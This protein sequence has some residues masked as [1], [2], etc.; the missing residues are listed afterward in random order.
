MKKYIETAKIMFKTQM[1]YRF[2]I[3]TSMIFTISKILLAYVLWGAIFGKQTVISG[4]TFNSML[5]YYIISTFLSQLDQSSNVG[6]QI[7]G[8]IRNGS[9]SKYIIRPIG[10]FRYFTAQTA[11]VTTFLLSFNLIAAV[12][13]IFIFRINFIISSNYYTIFAALS[14]TFL[15]LLFMIQINYFIGILAFKFLDT[16]IFMMIKDNLVQ[17]VTGALI[18]ITLLP[19]EIIRVMTFFPFY[20][21]SYLPSML[22]LNRNDNE[23]I[24]G[25]V[26]LTSWNIILG[27][28]NSI[29]YNRL[30]SVYDGVGI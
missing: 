20:Y 4:F 23:I 16:G 27:I 3:I 6:W 8:E 15:G 17:F 13:W 21:I 18:P 12:I 30:K 5:S 14:L 28:V 24:P 9:F 7:A 19:P 26:I 22:L 11:G 10:I 25:I 2:D 1:A 29:T